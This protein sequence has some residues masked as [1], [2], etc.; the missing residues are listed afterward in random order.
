MNSTPDW[1]KGG[2]ELKADPAGLRGFATNISTIAANLLSD[3]NGPMMDLFTSGGKFPLST[4]GLQAGASAEELSASNQA[5]TQAFCGDAYRSML[6]DGS[7][8]HTLA[9]CYEAGDGGNGISLSA[10]QW[11]YQE[12]GGKQPPGAP[13][14]LF[15]EGKLVTI[16]DLYAKGKGEA[17]AAGMDV[18]VG[19]VCL[20]D[21]TTI[22]TYR[23]AKGGERVVTTTGDKVEEIVKDKD[24]QT[25]YTMVS[26][27]T[28]STT[29]FYQDNK[30]AGSTVTTRSSSTNCPK[31]GPQTTHE[32]TT[33]EQRNANGEV[34]S[35]RT[36]HVETQRN[37]EN[38]TE[39]KT[40]YTT[41]GK[42]DKRIN[43]QRVGE[44][45]VPVKPKDWQD[46]A[47][48]EAARN[49]QLTGM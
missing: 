44:Q 43:E 35:R 27:S 5:S 18:K 28:G 34:T 8:F 33:V 15:P 4:G 6:A 21:G 13:S 14:Y 1:V 11:V 38:N 20:A 9:D 17:G 25:L 19:G 10:V 36:E 37:H 47:E 29:T 48:T 26:T 3:S 39:S 31:T 42:D 40:L 23:T 24:G 49:R 30:P 46:L 7:A 32:Q 41:E 22:T 2:D 16:N 45:P 12:P